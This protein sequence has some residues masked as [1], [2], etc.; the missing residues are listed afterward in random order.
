MV[1]NILEKL[2]SNLLKVGSKKQALEKGLNILED[3]GVTDITEY[4]RSIHAEMSAILHCARVGNSV[5]GATMFCTTFPCH[6]CAKHIIGSGIK[7]VVFVEPYPKSKAEWLH[8]NALSIG[9]KEKRKVLFEPFVGV[10]ARRYFDLFSLK[11]GWGQELKRK[12]KITGEIEC[13][14]RKESTIRVPMVGE[15]Y[16]DNE[17]K[18]YQ[19]VNKKLEEIEV[20]MEE[21]QKELKN[22]KRVRQQKDETKDKDDFW[23]FIDEV[24]A[25]IANW[26]ESKRESMKYLFD[27]DYF[28]K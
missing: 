27:D 22:Q 7:R 18:A 26:P 16:K 15:V 4:S 21:S 3:S 25:E 10:S 8:G 5:K 13:F 12:D 6:N 14:N 23:R 28:R 19:E 24:E 20:K 17:K 1:I 2:Q 11:L 9:R